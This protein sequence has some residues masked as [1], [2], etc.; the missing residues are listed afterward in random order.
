M[1]IPSNLEIG[2]NLLKILNFE[3]PHTLRIEQSYYS[4][5]LTNP[6]LKISNSQI[7]IRYFSNVTLLG[8][9]YELIINEIKSQSILIFATPLE[10]LVGIN[11]L[12]LENSKI[13]RI[14]YGLKTYLIHES[15]IE[16][17]Q[18]PYTILEEIE[19]ELFD[20]L[21]Y[22]TPF[23]RNI[24][25]LLPRNKHKQE[26]I[27]IVEEDF[28]DKLLFTPHIN[29]LH[30]HYA[31]NE[32]IFLYN[33]HSDKKILSLIHKHL[34]YL[35]NFNTSHFEEAQIVELIYT[36]Y[37]LEVIDEEKDILFH[38][39]STQYYY[40]ITPNLELEIITTNKE[41]YALPCYL[42]SSL[43]FFY[44]FKDSQDFLSKNGVNNSYN[45]KELQE[46]VVK[47]EN[48]S[49]LTF[50]PF[51]I[52]FR[53][54]E[55]LRKIVS[56]KYYS[57]PI[58][59]HIITQILFNNKFRSK[60]EF[61]E[62]LDSLEDYNN[63]S[64]NDK[65]LKDKNYENQNQKNIT[66]SNIIENNTKK[67]SKKISDDESN[68]IISNLPKFNTMKKNYIFPQKH[69]E[70]S[71]EIIHSYIKNV[72]DEIITLTQLPENFELTP[73]KENNFFRYQYNICEN[74]IRKVY[75]ILKEITRLEKHIDSKGFDFNLNEFDMFNYNKLLEEFS[76]Q[77]RLSSQEIRILN[78]ISTFNASQ[79]Q[80]KVYYSTLLIKEINECFNSISKQN[81]NSLNYSQNKELELENQSE[82]QLNNQKFKNNSYKLHQLVSKFIDTSF[83]KDLNIYQNLK[84]PQSTE[85][86]NQELSKSDEND[87]IY[88]NIKKIIYII[89]TIKP[90]LIKNTCELEIKS[91]VILKESQILKNY[92][93]E[94]NIKISIVK[95]SSQINR[96]KNKILVT[97]N[98]YCLYLI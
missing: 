35:S 85:I 41:S 84:N 40:K 86:N 14:E 17:L 80:E 77:L 12:L 16:Y 52:S 44:P 45:L 58:E 87:E 68:S 48:F 27:R 65:E 13:I 1:N 6:H 32:H 8:L 75:Q 43:N 71:L 78:Q 5:P 66:D 7:E 64:Q 61:N 56:P 42:N 69:I 37:P 81:Q 90:Y 39:I 18:K 49:I 51:F 95:E 29:S 89:N 15:Q 79:L 63:E 76:K 11:I 91:Q 31:I 9:E 96:E 82:G 3:E 62:S 57:N 24:S 83:F 88:K 33:I 73:V 26:T 22:S 23:S 54:Q 21:S 38:H 47:D 4:T 19:V 55:F 72:T 46:L 28:F 30:L 74:L 94:N 10:H 36:K 25:F 97:N 92:L 70:K 98:N 60:L 50:T 34:H 2:F 20:E 53:L 93:L 59:Y 67:V